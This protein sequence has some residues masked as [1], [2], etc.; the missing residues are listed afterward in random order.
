MRTIVC[1]NAIHELYVDGK[2][3]ATAETPGYIP[4]NCG[5]GMEVGY[6][7]GTSPAEIRDHFHGTIDEVKVFEAALSTE[8]I[9]REESTHAP[10]CN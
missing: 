8:E 1:I 9:A 2:P 4:G 6:S 7:L 3:A 5:Q 10:H